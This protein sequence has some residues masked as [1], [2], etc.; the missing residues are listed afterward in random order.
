MKN[1]IIKLSLML[2]ALALCIACN[3]D[4][5]QGDSTYNVP[6]PNLTVSLDFANSQSLVEAETTYGFT[7]T[8]SEAQVV[9]VVVYL[10]Q[11]GGTATD[12]DD[13]SFPHSI[14][15]PSGTTSVSDVITIHAD[16]LI[17]DT[18]TATIEITS[19]VEANV[20]T[21]SGQTVNFSITNLTSG[22][23]AIGLD[24]A[25]TGFQF[26]D[27]SAFSP[28]DLADLRLLVSTGP[29]NTDLI[30]GA[31]GGSAESWTMSSSTPDGEYYV[32]ADFFTAMDE[33][34]DIDLT[35]TFNQVG[36]INHQTHT[37]GGALNGN[38]SCGSVFYVLAKITKS[39]ESYTF[40][41]VGSNS[42]VTAAPFVGTATVT[43]DDW[44]DYSIGDT[45][46]I[47]AGADAQEFWIRS[48]TNPFITN[49]AT[50][51]MVVTVD[52]L[53][54]DVTVQSNENFD[55]TGTPMDISGT[56]TVNACA[57]SISLTINF[58]VPGSVGVSGYAFDQAFNLQL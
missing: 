20:A 49:T 16:D 24:W 28:Y 8:L 50:A 46:E 1:K 54:A 6:S 39:G 18:E 22:D 19:G 47:E 35:L 23:L 7:V 44:A 37:F 48:Y 31:D 27:G 32:V 55:Y 14:R 33:T 41:E 30:G 36:I 17:E 40:E 52:P 34:F 2:S 3:T 4:D 51:Y 9:D 13:F 57:S 21:I 5:A 25:A 11:I 43:A 10:T 38:N 29:N 53:T 26:P 58:W 56:G 15:I 45:V 42:P 12:G